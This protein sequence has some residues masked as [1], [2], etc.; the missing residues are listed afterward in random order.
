MN[1][2]YFKKVKFDEKERN[3]TESILEH[4]NQIIHA[5]QR[6]WFSLLDGDL[7][8]VSITTIQIE[9]EDSGTEFEVDETLVEEIYNTIRFDQT[10]LNDND[11]DG[12]VHDDDDVHDEIDDATDHIH[13]DETFD[14]HHHCSY[15]QNYV[16][17]FD[18]I[19]AKFNR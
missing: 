13:S 8:D 11:N 3:E 12:N 1:A 17:N 19:R 15:C 16:T 5:K 10:N 14:E 4:L 2:K 18:R 7:E 6:H 9:N